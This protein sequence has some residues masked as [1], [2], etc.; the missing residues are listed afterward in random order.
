MATM[1][2]IQAMNRL[3]S[4][5]QTWVAN[6]LRVKVNAELKTGSTEEYKVLSDNNFTDADKNRL[7]NLSLNAGTVTSVSAGTGLSGG[8]ITSSGTITLKT[9]SISEG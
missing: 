7:D 1:N 2:I 6:N 8:P 4:D 9:S 5:I 3:R